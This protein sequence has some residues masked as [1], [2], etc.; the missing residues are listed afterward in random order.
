MRDLIQ[1]NE[2]YIRRYEELRHSITDTT[3][4]NPQNLLLGFHVEEGSGYAIP[5]VEICLKDETKV[6]HLHHFVLL[7]DR[8]QAEVDM[9]SYQIGRGSR[10]R[11]QKQISYAQ[12]SETE[13]LRMLHGEAVM[14]GI[15]RKMGRATVAVPEDHASQ[16][17]NS[18]LVNLVSSKR[19]KRR[20]TKSTP[21]PPCRQ[22]NFTARASPPPSSNHKTQAFVEESTSWF[23][24]KDEAES[25][26]APLNSPSASLPHLSQNCT[27]TQESEKV[28]APLQNTM[29]TT[30]VED[31]T[32]LKSKIKAAIE[33]QDQIQGADVPASKDNNHRKAHWQAQLEFAEMADKPDK[34]RNQNDEDNNV[35]QAEDCEVSTYN[36]WKLRTNSAS[37]RPDWASDGDTSTNPEISEDEEYQIIDTMLDDLLE[38]WTPLT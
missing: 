4:A 6:E 20:G 15:W 32:R 19:P 18:G 7:F 30:P 2:E 12:E 26:D 1:S 8:L 16:P 10:S 13:Q 34:V 17:P 38:L 28:Q 22:I 5:D 27:P 21:P 36:M 29:S 23:G 35:D 25:Q 37:I 11:I 33:Q 3:S 14:G 24:S 31:V 9:P